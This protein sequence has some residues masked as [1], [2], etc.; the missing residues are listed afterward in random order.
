MNHIRKLLKAVQPQSALEIPRGRG[1][2][3]TGEKIKPLDADRAA[4]SSY[5]YGRHWVSCSADL[6]SFIHK[7]GSVSYLACWPIYVSQCMSNN[8]IRSAVSDWDPKRQCL[9]REQTFFC[10]KAYSCA[11]WAGLDTPLSKVLRIHFISVHFSTISKMRACLLGP[12][13]LHL[14]PC[15]RRRLEK[16][17]K[18]LR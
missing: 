16:G 11:T 7:L 4:F 3:G 8:S 5:K 2:T 10:L 14:Y 1:G 18:K 6:M 13:W 15:S 17:L 9:N 12:L